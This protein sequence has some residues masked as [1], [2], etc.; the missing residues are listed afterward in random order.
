MLQI[1]DTQWSDID[2]MRGHLDWT[3]DPVAFKHLPDVV[4]FLH[5]MNMHYA[6]IVDPGISNEQPAGTYPTYDRGIDMN[7]FVRDSRTGKP[8]VGRVRAAVCT[9]NYNSKI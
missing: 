8:I 1:K 6:I 4:R 2:Y 5:S 9:L 7:L 3:Y